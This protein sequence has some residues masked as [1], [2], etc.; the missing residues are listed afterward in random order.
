M[1]TK[2][3]GQKTSQVGRQT[4]LTKELA[5]DLYDYIRKG[6]THKAAYMACG[7]S[8]Q[9]F[10][11]WINWGKAGKSPEYIEF[12]DT[13]K[14]AEGE[15]YAAHSVNVTKIAA[16][17]NITGSIYWL[18]NRHPDEWQD[19]RNHEVKQEIVIKDK[20]DEALKEEI[21]TMVE[22]LQEYV[23]SSS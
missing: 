1:T 9:T 17:G 13:I 20:T 2:K 7:V 8:N 3:T 10:Y 14:K 23:N 6:C 5:N 15:A 4:K 22:D 12:F 16:K 21:K 11:N 19:K 18:Q